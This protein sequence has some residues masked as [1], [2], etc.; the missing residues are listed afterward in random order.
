MPEALFALL[1]CHAIA[2][3]RAVP[4]ASFHKRRW[5]LIHTIVFARTLSSYRTFDLL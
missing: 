1:L 3:E 4:P 2:A 5:I